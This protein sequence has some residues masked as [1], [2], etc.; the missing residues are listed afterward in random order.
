MILLA[1]SACI[2][3]L[4]P[5][6]DDQNANWYQKAILYTSLYIVALGTGGIKPNVSAFGADQFDETNPKVRCLP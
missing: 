3:G 1:A 6:Y 4:T 5:E 2:P